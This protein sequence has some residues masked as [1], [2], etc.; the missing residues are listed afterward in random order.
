MATALRQTE[1]VLWRHRTATVGT[2][3]TYPLFPLLRNP[4]RGVNSVTQIHD[5]LILVL[6]TSIEVVN[7]S[8]GEAMGVTIEARRAT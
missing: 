4:F 7:I 6:C 3:V 2:L 1:S 8:N 5:V